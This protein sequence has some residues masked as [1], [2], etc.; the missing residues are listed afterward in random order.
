MNSTNVFRVW[1]LPSLILFLVVS[2][3][4]SAV[5]QTT[6]EAAS[7]CSVHVELFFDMST[8]LNSK[9]QALIDG[10]NQLLRRQ[11]S[12]FPTTTT[13]NLS[14][15]ANRVL[16]PIPLDW[17]ELLTENKLS[18][19]LPHDFDRDKTDLLEVLRKLSTL[20]SKSDGIYTVFVI[21]SDFKH[22]PFNKT[23]EAAISKY[24]EDTEEFFGE[25]SSALAEAF[26]KGANKG[27]LL[28][29]TENP[30]ENTLQSLIINSIL[31]LKTQKL[32]RGQI[33]NFPLGPRTFK[34]NDFLSY[35]QTLEVK[36]IREGAI[37]NDTDEAK[38][39]VIANPRSGE[40]FK[41]AGQLYYDL[42]FAQDANEARQLG[43]FKNLK[44]EKDRDKAEWRNTQ[45][46]SGS[47]LPNGIAS[48]EE[49]RAY[50]R[51]R[52]QP[53]GD[54]E[55]PT[56]VAHLRD[57]IIV[58]HFDG[59]PTVFNN[60]FSMAFTVKGEI[61]GPQEAMLRFE[62]FC[63]SAVLGDSESN[64]KASGRPF[65]KKSDFQD[66]SQAVP[67]SFILPV[68]NL[69]EICAND[70][71]DPKHFFMRITGD[72]VSKRSRCLSVHVNRNHNGNPEHLLRTLFEQASLPACLTV[73][74]TLGFAWK[75]A[76]EI[77]KLEKLLAVFAIGSTSLLILLHQHVG[78][79]KKIMDALLEGWPSV[80][81]ALFTILGFTLLASRVMQRGGLPLSRGF[82]GDLVEF[83]DLDA[84]GKSLEHHT[85]KRRV[86]PRSF[87]VV[88]ISLVAVGLGGLVVASSPEKEYC[89]I[90]GDLRT[91]A[92]DVPQCDSQ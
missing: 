63:S 46:V 26:S 42:Y 60:S 43:R 68:E 74:L 18:E 7:E 5:Q 59:V 22:D 86:R 88:L 67:K 31:R 77:E 38:I 87:W 13:I 3:S 53:T 69:T 58:P 47:D 78:P 64:A 2:A 90:S 34:D 6:T 10:V 82:R 71:K 50:V 79:I 37:N 11:N 27:L 85:R 84:R 32:G 49:I 4:G 56:G 72:L 44:L 20:S 1:S 80:I 51:R 28:I 16:D 65:V 61:T 92:N 55:I 15:F 40:C 57:Y 24:K 23:D 29:S 73:F 66:S 62:L 21:A 81:V 89:W 25:Q 70:P 33:A 45:T 9:H 54:L 39:T 8:S 36:V 30:S 12:P 35:F 17:K 48:E 41:A 76:D 83:I 52:E 91:D 75:R 14:R 19:N